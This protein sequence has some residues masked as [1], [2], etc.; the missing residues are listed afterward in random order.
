MQNPYIR[1]REDGLLFIVGTRVPLAA[2]AYEYRRGESPEAI[3]YSYPAL[4][5]EQVYGAITYCLA[6]PAAVTAYLKRLDRAY[7]RARRASGP[8]QRPARR[9][10]PP[11]A[12]RARAG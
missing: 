10:R 2:V 6:E 4:T 3:L 5:L 9:P 12:R 1:Q 8:Q 11:A 7:D